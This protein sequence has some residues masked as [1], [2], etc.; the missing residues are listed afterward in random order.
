MLLGTVMSDENDAESE[1]SRGEGKIKEGKAEKGTKKGDLRFRG[2]A[3]GCYASNTAA[4]WCVISAS[5][6]TSLLIHTL[7]VDCLIQLVAAC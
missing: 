5:S 4:I 1:E 6:R 7:P 2:L 3:Q